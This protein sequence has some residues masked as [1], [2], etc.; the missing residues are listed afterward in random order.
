M[1]DETE[2]RLAALE[3]RY[4]E[5]EAASV[6]QTQCVDVLVGLLEHG[7]AEPFRSQLRGMYRQA[8]RES[9]ET[10]LRTA[11]DDAP[12]LASRL[13][14]ILRHQLDQTPPA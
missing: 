2:K 1:S 8:V 3:Q 7:V 14:E 4:L 11:A 12:N 6:M 10:F 13:R 5:L 9:T